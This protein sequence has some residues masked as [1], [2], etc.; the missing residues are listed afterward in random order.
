LNRVARS[1][2]YYSGLLGAARQFRRQSL[3]I[4]LYHRFDISADGPSRLE[5]QCQ[6]IR[7]H[8]AP[9]SLSE[10]AE[11]F[12][13]GQR[14]PPNSIA[15]TVDDGHRDFL[16]HALPTF[17]RYKIPVT[18]FVVADAADGKDWLWSDQI[19]HLVAQTK[20][21]S[22]EIGGRAIDLKIDPRRA[23]NRIMES[24]KRVPNRERLRMLGELAEKFGVDIPT[25]A[26]PDYGL[27]QWWE[28]RTL[29]KQGVEIGCH[30]KTHP[31]LSQV[32]DQRELID[33]IS[34]AKAQIEAELRTPVV[35]FAY[36]NGTWDDFNPEIASV[37]KSSGFRC[38]VAAETGFNDVGHDSFALLRLG[39]EPGFS[40]K[41][42]AELLAG[43][44]KY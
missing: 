3:R 44:R 8:Y 11:N 16:Q 7:R 6:H 41:R 27:L 29:A 43:V 1:A 26:P 20:R 19:S 9:I 22:I 42:F 33:E 12:E 14:L 10:A 40:K 15:V 39:V 34:G 24:L 5:W 30:S 17:S 28:L 23:A 18:L 25:K 37:V 35:H 2:L 21:E 38:A 4:L 36:P 13:R 31:I 32:E